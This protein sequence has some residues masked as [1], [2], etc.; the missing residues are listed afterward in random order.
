MSITRGEEASPALFQKLEKLE[1]PGEK[2]EIFLCWARLKIIFQRK[3]PLSCKLLASNQLHYKLLIQH[4]THTHLNFIK[5]KKLLISAPLIWRPRF[6]LKNP[7]NLKL[8]SFFSIIFSITKTC[9][10][11]PNEPHKYGAGLVISLNF[12]LPLFLYQHQV[13][14]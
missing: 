6:L 4:L 5:I 7:R 11:S 2:T 3:K 8:S 13:K 9:L 12:L 10:L 14:I 1:S